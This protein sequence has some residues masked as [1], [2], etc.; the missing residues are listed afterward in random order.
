MILEEG[1]DG[2][3]AGGRDIDGQFV[4]PDGELLDVFWEA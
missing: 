4:F 1:D 3:D 2:Y